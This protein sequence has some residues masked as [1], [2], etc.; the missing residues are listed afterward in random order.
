MAAPYQAV[1]AKDGYFVL[2]ANNDRLWRRL[3]EAIDRPELVEHP[4]YRSNADRLAHREALAA[5]LES[6]FVSRDRA[7]WVD[8]LLA[9]GIPADA[10]S[11]YDEVLESPQAKARG[12][13][14]TIEHPVE[15]EVPN[16]GFPVK[17]SGTPQQVRRHPPLL[18]EHN[19]EIFAELGIADDEA[20][21]AVGGSP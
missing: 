10:I 11:E 12:V 14:M 4:D 19:A 21:L 20:L 18:G 8:K 7:Y 2:G 16:I 1:R 9:I 5:E 15:G 13:R 3:L 17:L 6:T